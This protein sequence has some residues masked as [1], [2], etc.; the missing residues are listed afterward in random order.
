MLQLAGSNGHSQQIKPPKESMRH[1]VSGF[2]RS[3]LRMPLHEPSGH[4]AIQLRKMSREKMV[5]AAERSATLVFSRTSAGN[6]STIARSL[7]GGPNRSNSPDTRSFGLSQ[8]IEIGKA[9][10]AKIADRQPETD[11]LGYARIAAPGAQPDPGTK[12]ES[13]EEQ[14]HTRDIPPQ[15][16]QSRPRTSCVSPT[17]FVVGSFAEAN[18]AKIK[19]HDR[20]AK[21]V[22][23]FRGLVNHFIV[24][25]PAKQRMRVADDRGQR[26]PARRHLF[27]EVAHRSV[28]IRPAGPGSINVR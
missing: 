9:A 8:R 22:N 19:P 6:C 3:K 1:L 4:R 17:P 21:P 23:R 14:R 11:E 27:R 26:R 24:H 20:Q 16:N 12:T 13:R 28:S 2:A 10:G 25:R 18:A 15:E 5:P 7:I